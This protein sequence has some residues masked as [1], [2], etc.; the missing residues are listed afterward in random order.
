MRF[1]DYLELW[2]VKREKYITNNENPMTIKE[3]PLA[4]NVYPETLFRD[5]YK[6]KL[7]EILEKDEISED[8]LIL[9]ISEKQ[10]IPTVDRISESEF[11]YKD[12]IEAFVQRIHDYTNDLRIRFAIDDFGVGHSSISRLY[13][14]DL[15]YIKIDREILLHSNPGL[16]IDYVKNFENAI[17]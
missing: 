2:Q 4:I 5:A 10:P 12:P 8:R 14:F 15:D 11:T 1:Y 9:E 6:K 7:T 16:T 3:D 13:S 17:H